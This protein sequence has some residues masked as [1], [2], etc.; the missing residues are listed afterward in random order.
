MTSQ[1]SSKERALTRD[2]VLSYL[3]Y[4][5][6]TGQFWRLKSYQKRFV[7]RPAGHIGADGY[8]LI[9]MLIPSS[10]RPKSLPVFAHRLAW[11]IAH[12]EWPSG[13][14]DHIN[15]DRSDN[16]LRNLRVASKS[17]NQQ[18]RRARQNS[19]SGYLGVTERF[20]FGKLKYQADIQADKKRWYLGS[21][22]TAIE[23]HQAYLEAKS[24][25]H[26][27]QP[28]YRYVPACSTDSHEA[29]YV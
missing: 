14:I 12:G 4:D 13:E 25:L 16:R 3:R 18:N 19:R 9:T 10:T 26:K 15:G 17:Q 24:R 5:E 11:L 20:V 7:G 22:S 23:A 2:Y 21:F 28:T 8:V 1:A 6:Q 27:F 29:T